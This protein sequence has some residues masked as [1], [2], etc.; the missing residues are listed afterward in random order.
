MER[1]QPDWGKLA[2]RG[3]PNTAD[4]DGGYVRDWQAKKRNS[5]VAEAV[6]I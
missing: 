2:I 5:E 4:T 6:V 3:R 1:C